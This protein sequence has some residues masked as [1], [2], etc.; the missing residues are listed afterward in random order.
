MI[1][2]RY[3]VLH[4]SLQLQ[5]RQQFEVINITEDIQRWI[6]QNHLAS[7][8]VTVFTPHTTAAIKLNHFE[9]LLLQDISRTLYR[10]VPQDI[11]YNHDLFELRQN[12]K[13]NERSNGHA[14]VKAFV[15]GASENIPLQ[16]G[17]LLMGDRQS[18]LFVECDGSRKRT[19]HL[20]FV[21]EEAQ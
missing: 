14:H 18:I 10:L 6:A 21:G 17:Q 12:V 16:G 9:P 11:S 4:T 15:L 20:T 2:C 19:V 3:M 8:A 5:T 1:Y 7:G 13:P